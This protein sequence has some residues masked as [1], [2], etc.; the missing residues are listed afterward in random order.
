MQRKKNFGHLWIRYRQ[1]SMFIE[2]DPK[3]NV[4]GSRMYLTQARDV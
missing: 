3:K 4:V 1:V 2:M